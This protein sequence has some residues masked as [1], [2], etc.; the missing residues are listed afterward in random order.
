MSSWNPIVDEILKIKELNEKI[1]DISHNLLSR[2]T[3][4]S[5]K[6]TENDI[7]IDNKTMALVAEVR[8]THRLVHNLPP[9]MNTIINT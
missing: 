2:S 5:K 6:C 4:L 1:L 9:K 3:Y 7:S 8:K